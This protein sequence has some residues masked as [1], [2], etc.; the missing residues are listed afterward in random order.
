MICFLPSLNCFGC[1]FVKDMFSGKGKFDNVTFA[2][3]A[4]ATQLCSDFITCQFRFAKVPVHQRIH[5]QVFIG[6]HFYADISA[7]C[8]I[9]RTN[10]ERNLFSLIGFERI[11]L[12]RRELR[13]ELGCNQIAVLNLDIE[14]V[15]GREPDKAGDE[16]IGGCIVEFKGSAHL[17]HMPHGHA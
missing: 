7:F 14:E 17:L 4:P 6:E 15:H 3:I 16:K 13:T 12:F 1:L 8:H 10:A 5:A 9:L 2:I 11:C